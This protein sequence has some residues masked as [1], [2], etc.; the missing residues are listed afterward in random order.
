MSVKKH[1]ILVLA[2]YIGETHNSTAYYWSQIVKNLQ[3]SF[4]VILIVPDTKHARNFS[5]QY[6]VATKYVNFVGHNKNNLLSRLYG[7]L[8][9]TYNFWKSIHRDI[10][11]VDLVFS[12]TNPIITMFFMAGM[13]MRKKFKWLVLVHD[14]F[15]NNLIPAKLIKGTSFFYRT[16]SYV[17]DKVYSSPDGMICIGRDMKKLLEEKTGVSENIKF[18]PNWSSTE[19]IFD[20]CKDDNE[21]INDLGWNNRVVFQFFGNMGRLQGIDNLLKAIKLTEHENARFLF[22]GGG[23]EELSVENEA[24]KINVSVGYQKIHYYGQLE[25]E[26]NNIGLNACD[27]AFVTLSENMFGLG[28]PSKA[29]FSMAADKPL[30]YVGDEGSELELLLSEH[31]NELG[32]YCKNG[33][34]KQL[35]ELI[36]HITEGY[37]KGD[38]HSRFNPR[39][40]LENSFSEQMALNSI[41]NI[42][43]EVIE[44]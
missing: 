9:Q 41:L 17:S 32:W 30:L 18:V 15:P 44:K 23:S 10:G 7:Q 29:Y 25:I 13:R 8:L 40:I 2:E 14:V 3:Q 33:A 20:S 22:I 36:D 28:V 35:A 43:Q 19:N 39:K 5:E 24:E 21:I 11:T 1:K 42:A 37:S 6:R 34:P 12:G 27:V 38:F 26:K 4:D 16:I 31:E